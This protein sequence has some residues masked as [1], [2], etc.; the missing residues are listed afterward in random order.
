MNDITKHD[1]KLEGEG[2]N[3]EDS[4]VDFFV[5]GYAIGVHN[6]LESPG[7]FIGVKEGGTKEGLALTVNFLDLGR[8]KRAAV[9]EFRNLCIKW[10]AVFGWTPH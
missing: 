9:S 10:L 6:F 7:E 4:R 3:G 2:N 5:V 1:T 8:V